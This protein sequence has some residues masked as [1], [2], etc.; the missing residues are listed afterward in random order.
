MYADDVK[1]CLQYK[2]TS[3]HL[4]LQSHLDRFQIWCRDNVLDLL[5]VLDLK[6]KVMTFCRFNPIRTTYTLSGCPV[7]RI[8]RVDD[9]GVLLDPKLKFSNHIS[10]IVNKARGVLGFIKRWSK[11]FDDP[12]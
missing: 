6:C 9:L 11:E 10:T 12:Y 1:L 2:D 3:C 8:T 5:D 7:N 4:D